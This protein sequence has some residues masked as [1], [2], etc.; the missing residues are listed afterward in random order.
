VAIDADKYRKVMS[1][2]AT[3][4][5]VVTTNVDGNLHG[6]TANAVTSVSLE[7]LLL[8]VCVDK[9]ARALEELRVAETFG[10]SILSEAQQD[11]SNTFAMRGE[12]EPASLRGLAYT[13]GET[14]VPWVAGAIAQLECRTTEHL[15]GGDHV[16]VIGE[17]VVAEILSDEPPLLFYQGKYRVL[18]S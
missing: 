1:A 17:V 14:G 11:V 8:L 3:G 4:V 13:M 15:E 10:V 9:R 12:P 5:T 7:P 16:I 18:G 2:F 6:F